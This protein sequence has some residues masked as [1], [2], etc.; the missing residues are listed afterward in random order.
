MS[1]YDRTFCSN[2]KCKQTEC[3]LHQ[4]NIKDIWRSISV[5]DYENTEYCKAKQRCGDCKHKGH[6]DTTSK[7]YGVPKYNGG[8]KYFEA[9]MKGE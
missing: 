7:L 1:Y 4:H 5:A 2:R 9:E 3:D 6:C 8:C